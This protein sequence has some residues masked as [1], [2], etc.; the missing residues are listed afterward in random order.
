MAITPTSAPIR[1]A[2]APTV[3]AACTLWVPGIQPVGSGNLIDRSGLGNHGTR[4][5]NI[6][7]AQL[8]S[9]E[10]WAH[11]ITAGAGANGAGGFEFPA[12]AFPWNAQNGDSFIMAFECKRAAGVPSTGGRIGGNGP[13]GTMAGIVIGAASGTGKTQIR[14]SNSGGTS[15]LTAVHSTPIMTTSPHR[16]VI[17]HHSHRKRLMLWVD[18]GAPIELN[19]PNIIT[20]STDAYAV[21]GQKLA[22]GNSDSTGAA[23]TIACEF[24]NICV[25]S[26]ANDAP[27]ADFWGIVA[28]YMKNPFGGLRSQR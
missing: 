26:Y 27:P 16:V 6:S 5:S 18:S 23:G 12:A 22:F 1:V 10:G 24:R 11:A 13:S 3:D 14:I 19:V 8:W 7:D 4:Q 9:D 15:Y 20:S 2:A 21:H 17:A 28:Q 25:L